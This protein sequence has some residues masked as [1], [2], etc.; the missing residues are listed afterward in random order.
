M[1]LKN[2]I[3][4]DGLKRQYR[5]EDVPEGCV[6]VEKAKAAPRASTKKGGAK[7]EG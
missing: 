3:C 5:D 7:D 2:Y 4:P 6:P 1:A